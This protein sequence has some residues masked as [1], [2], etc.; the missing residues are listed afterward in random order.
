MCHLDSVVY[1]NLIPRHRSRAGLGE[2]DNSEGRGVDRAE[3]DAA[4]EE[5]GD[6]DLDAM[7]EEIEE[8]EEDELENE[9]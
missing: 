5:L 9:Y 8:D 1:H 6:A 3:F 4:A 2:E 7:D